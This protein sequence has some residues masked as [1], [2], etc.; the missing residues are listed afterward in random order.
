VTFSPCFPCSRIKALGDIYPTLIADNR[1]LQTVGLEQ[2]L[3][4]QEERARR[5]VVYADIRYQVDEA[6][7]CQ[8]FGEPEG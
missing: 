3:A 7:R 5:G 6:V 4:E 1:R 2:W 8:A